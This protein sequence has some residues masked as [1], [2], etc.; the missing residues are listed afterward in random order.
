MNEVTATRVDS[1]RRKVRMAEFH[2]Y[3]LSQLRLLWAKTDEEEVLIRTAALLEGCLHSLHHCLDLLGHAIA[4]E[5]PGLMSGDR[6]Y[7]N[8]VV[9]R[10]SPGV[11]KTKCHQLFTQADT[12]W[13][14]GFVNYSKHHNL[15]E[16]SPAYVVGSS[17]VSVTVQGL[18]GPGPVPLDVFVRSFHYKGRAMDSV[19]ALSA[20]NFFCD[21]IKS[22]LEEIIAEL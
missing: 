2:R 14:I 18:T 4:S 15:L 22:R 3:Q 1:I 11:L 5:H 17:G 6:F 7:F 12:Q 10:L 21:F 16:M 13:L 20:A 19:P 8:D 9:R